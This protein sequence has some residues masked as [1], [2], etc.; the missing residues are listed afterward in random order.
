MKS[1]EEGLDAW[2]VNNE[3]A[4]TKAL[5]G[6][7]EVVCVSGSIY[8]YQVDAWLANNENAITE[9]LY[10]GSSVVYVSNSPDQVEAAGNI[11][12]EE[13]KEEAEG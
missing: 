6:G 4:I 3:N 7:N 1:K 8:Q 12:A 13:G 9:A 10:G 11:A 2:L 5:Y